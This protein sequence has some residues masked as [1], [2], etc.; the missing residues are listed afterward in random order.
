M[1]SFITEETVKRVTPLCQRISPST[2]VDCSAELE[3]KERKRLGIEDNN[4]EVFNHVK[5][6]FT[7]IP[8]Q[9]FPNGAKP[10]E[11]TRCNMDHSFVLESMLK[12]LD[13]SDG[14]S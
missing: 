7:N 13:G 2:Q 14:K 1:T 8:E 6:R 12:K 4:S 3:K 10:H 9:K 5:I 11:I